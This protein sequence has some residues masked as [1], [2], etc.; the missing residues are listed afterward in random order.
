MIGTTAKQKSSLHA[1]VT[2]ADG[3]TENYRYLAGGG[4]IGKLVRLERAVKGALNGSR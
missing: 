3:R 1:V 4:I 2:R